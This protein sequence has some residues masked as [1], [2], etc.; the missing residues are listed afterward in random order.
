MRIKFTS[1]LL[2][3]FLTISLHSV[4]PIFA[5]ET[6]ETKWVLENII[7]GEGGEDIAPNGTRRDIVRGPS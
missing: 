1:L 3:L 4:R 6:T 7:V 2:I 5:E